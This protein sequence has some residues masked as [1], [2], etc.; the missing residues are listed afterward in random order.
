LPAFFTAGL[1][2]LFFFGAVFLDFVA[3]RSD[4]HGITKNG[5][6]IFWESSD[7]DTRKN[8]PRGAST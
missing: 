4:V 5:T 1:A 7:F 6:H 3:M 8:C 2:A